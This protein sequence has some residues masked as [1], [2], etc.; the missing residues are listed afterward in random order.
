MAQQKALLLLE[1]QGSFKVGELSIPKPGKGEILV[2]I[3]ATALNPVDWKIRK[4]GRFITEYPAVLGTDSSGIVEEVGEGV[5]TFQKGDK[6]FHQ[7]YFTNATAT[8]QQYTT[9]PAEI[10][11]KLPSNLSFDQAA[12]IPLG[13]ATAAVGFY[14]SHEKQGAG[15]QAP[16][17]GGEG[18]YTGQGVVIFGGSSS[19]GQYESMSYLNSICPVIQ[20]AKLSGFSPII[21]TSSLHNTDLVKSLGATHVIDRKAD[22]VGEVKKILSDSPKIVYDAISLEDTQKQAIQIVAPGGIL[23]LVLPAV[24]AVKSVQGDKNVFTVFGTVHVQRELGISLYSKVTEYL[25]SGK[26]KPNRVEILPDGLAGIPDGLQKMEDN[27]V[28]GVKLIARPQET[29]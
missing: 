6:V 26:L 25:E 9:V 12:S 4:L 15:L 17:E 28:S 2:K 22:V 14:H 18:K 13:L 16:W 27:K 1:K 23:L 8:F 20:L 5:T 24:E 19:V 21:T 10:A 29:S 3:Y 7:G 11:A